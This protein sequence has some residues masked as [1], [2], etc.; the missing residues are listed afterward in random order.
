MAGDPARRPAAGCAVVAGGLCVAAI[1]LPA[2][3][4]LTDNIVYFRTVS[5]AVRERD[6]DGE[7]A[8]AHGGHGRG[9]LAAWPSADGVAF[10]VTEG[11]ERCQGVPPG[12][13]ARAV[14]RRRAGGVRGPLGR[15]R[16]PLR[17]DHDQAR[18]EYKPP[19]RD[20]PRVLRAAL[21]FA[22]VALGFSAAVTACGPGHR[23]APRD[24]ARL[25]ARAAVAL[26]V[27]AGAVSAAG[28][29]EWAL[30]T[31]DF[32][33]RYVVE[34]HAPR[35]AVA[36]HGG[37]AVGRAGR[38]DPA[39]GPRARRLPDRRDPAVPGPGRR[40]A[41]GLG[42]P[43]RAW[44]W[45]LS[46][47]ASCWARPTPSRRSRAAIPLDGRGPNPLLQNH[48]LM[49]IHP[50]MLYL[51]YVGFT[52]PF[53]FAV[54]ALV[55]GRVGEGWLVETR[56]ATLVAWG[57]LSAGIV[58]GAWWSYEVLGWGGYWAWDPV[59]N[60]S[61]IPWLT[62]TA[63]LH[64]VVVQERR[65]MLRV[66][67]LS[68]ILATF[69]LTILGTFLTRSGVIDSV[70]SFTQ[71]AIGPLLLGFL[72]VAAA[73]GVGLIAWRGDRL[74][75]PGRIDSPVS[76]EGAFLANNLLFAG[77]AFVVLLG[78]VFPLLAEAL[79]QRQL[80]VGE[81][82]FDQMTLPIGLALLFLMA[83]APA[84]PWRAA[85]GEVLRGR[86][87]GPAWAGALTMAAAAATG[88]RG[89]AQLVAFGL[90]AF[91]VA[92]IVRQYRLGVVARRRSSGE[93]WPAALRSTVAGNRRLYGGL[94]VHSGIVVI[95]VALAASSGYSTKREFQMRPGERVAM[96][97]HRFTYLGSEETET[98]QKR[99]LT[100]RVRVDRGGKSLGVY[101]PA[102]S[103]FPNMAQA[104]GTPSVR[105]SLLRDVYL[106]LVSSPDADGQVKLGVQ[107]NPLVVWLW[108]GGGIVVAGTTIAVW[109]ARR[110]R[111]G[112]VP[113]STSPDPVPPEEQPAEEIVGSRP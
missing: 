33:I 102:L 59:E 62:A 99:T 82:Y 46:S 34:N 24:D 86:L 47:S 79:Q 108:I 83:V 43:H 14:R 10:V 11:D 91:A 85:S 52:I 37:V 12:R 78:T 109:P 27:L 63:Y 110:S 29:M 74:R 22:G 97:G 112:A 72:G 44:W 49:A 94:V 7:D 71:S 67:N 56:R 58:L 18:L 68:L 23:A 73:T 70:H 113:A 16:V 106:T 26:L 40:P 75:T 35:D 41:G 55:T 50:P 89:V 28:A 81:P 53:S 4:R 6:E 87:A 84:L 1:A 2:L 111:R 90:G 76:R 65:G 64:S 15:R 101:E 77:F 107:V 93:G 103:I 54:A 21:G 105:T 80:S 51:G 3:R 42:H 98:G 48:P 88:A 17:P 13:P 20:S 9:R 30:L 45:P 100:A 96:A 39:V 31:H 61:F 92:G 36:V 57:F 95:A 8:G 60:A 69:C 38:L 32:S 19:R 25:L 104:I 5:E 66:W